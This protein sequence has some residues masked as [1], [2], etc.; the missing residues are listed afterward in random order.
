MI[1]RLE[2]ESIRFYK[3]FLHKNK[4][5]L[6]STKT[7]ETLQGILKDEAKHVAITHRLLDILQHEKVQTLVGK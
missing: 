1:L 3:D 6:E 4:S 5:L 2:E 7:Y